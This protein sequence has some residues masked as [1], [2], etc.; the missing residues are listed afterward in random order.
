MTDA[1]KIKRYGEVIGEYNSNHNPANIYQVRWHPERG[2]SCQC[3]G[4]RFSKASPREC[5]HTRHASEA[6][7]RSD[8][9][10]TEA[11][12][13]LECCRILLRTAL[14]S[15][16]RDE[17]G[18]FRASF[19]AKELAATTMEKQLAKWMAK[20]SHETTPAPQRR[21][22]VGAVRLITLED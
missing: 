10:P 20:H 17:P 13:T 11:A 12:P 14:S 6:G 16:T 9:C 19:Q 3:P 1:Q 22:I 8:T 18:Q 4:W 15:L 2:Y 21:S 5:R 7:L